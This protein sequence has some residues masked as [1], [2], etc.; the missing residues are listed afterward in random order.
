M[1]SHI[2]SARHENGQPTTRVSYVSYPYQ[3]TPMV[4]PH[5]SQWDGGMP[6]FPSVY[7]YPLV[8]GT[9]Y[10]YI[11]PSPSLHPSF[12][13]PWFSSLPLHSFTPS[14]PPTLILSVYPSIYFIDLSINLS[15]IMRAH[16]QILYLFLSHSLKHSQP[17][18]PPSQ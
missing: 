6:L 14:P 18:T 2:Y 13:L 9:I 10:I 17:P 1:S 3:W 5:G 8:F 7:V 16:T 15:N 11:Y 12:Y 4:I